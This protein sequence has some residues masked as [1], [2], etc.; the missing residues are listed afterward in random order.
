M[1]DCEAFALRQML[2]E[3]IS[4]FRKYRS[5]PDVARYQSWDETFSVDEAKCFVSKQINQLPNIPGEWIQIAICIDDESSTD[6]NSIVGDCAFCSELY[7]PDT[8]SIGNY[9]HEY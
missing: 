2:K 6:Y 1:I 9:N 5:N 8:V 7:Q 4:M 3:D